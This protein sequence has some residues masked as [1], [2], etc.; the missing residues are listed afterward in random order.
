VK[1]SVTRVFSVLTLP[2]I[3][4]ICNIRGSKIHAR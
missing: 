1:D 4:V 2:N 3:I